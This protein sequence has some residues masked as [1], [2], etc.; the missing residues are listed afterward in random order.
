MID[1]IIQQQ[2]NYYCARAS[3]YDEWFYRQGRYDRGE[4]I[5]KRWFQ[6]VD[7]VKNAL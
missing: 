7:I 4:E 5:N 3:E 1:N 2:I 6:E